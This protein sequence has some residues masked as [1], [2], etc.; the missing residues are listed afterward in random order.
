MIHPSDLLH[1]VNIAEGGDEIGI[2]TEFLNSLQDSKGFFE[3]RKGTFLK[4]IAMTTIGVATGAALDRS[5]EGIAAG[6][7]IA[8]IAE[9]AVDLGLDLL[10]EFLLS[11]LRGGSQECSSTT[12]VH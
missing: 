12:C 10:D 1:A 6:A 9:P 4:S 11:T 7:V 5:L 2:S 3:T 8:K